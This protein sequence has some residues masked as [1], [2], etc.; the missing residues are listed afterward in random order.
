MVEGDGW[1][2]QWAS[3]EATVSQLDTYP[4]L[5]YFVCVPVGWKGAKYEFLLCSVLGV[6][7][8]GAG[9]R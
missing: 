8:A 5:P 2:R 3:Y 9:G 1:S 4:P 6:S 7:M